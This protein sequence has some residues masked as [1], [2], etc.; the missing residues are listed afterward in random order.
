[1]SD[2]TFHV[3]P[4]P[5][6]RGVAPVWPV[7]AERPAGTPADRRPEPDGHVVAASTGGNLRAAY[8]QFV[9]DPETHEVSVRVKDANTDQ[10]L[11]EY[12]SKQVQ[13]MTEYLRNYADTLARHRMANLKNGLA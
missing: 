1:M 5:P 13:Q 8:A 7:R 10:V 12:P 2:S 3:E 6:V 9:I 11:N 4:T